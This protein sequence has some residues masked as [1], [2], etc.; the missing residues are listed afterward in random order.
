MSAGSGAGGRLSS[1][2][3]GQSSAPAVTSAHSFI[4]EA[5]EVSL[6]L[7]DPDLRQRAEALVRDVTPWPAFKARVL[8]SHEWH[9][10]ARRMG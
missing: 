6:A 5:V 2:A 7:E 1:G 8:G 4:R 9:D 3:I 10:S